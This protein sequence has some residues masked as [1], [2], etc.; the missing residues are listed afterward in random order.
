MNQLIKTLLVFTSVSSTMALVSACAETE[1]EEGSIGTNSS[2]IAAAPRI[3][4]FNRECGTSESGACPAQPDCPNLPN[5]TACTTTGSRCLT[6]PNPSGRRKVFACVPGNVNGWAFNGN[7]EGTCT[8][9]A[10]PDIPTGVAG[11][12]CTTPL[13]RCSS[14]NRVFACIPPG[15]VYIFNGYCGKNGGPACASFADNCPSLASGVAGTA[16]TAGSTCKS[17][18]TD[19]LSGKVFKCVSR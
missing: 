11:A 1:S 18:G 5:G 6:G 16:C 9:P 15:D 10:C 12:P 7:C 13:A 17:I 14:A 2:E 8:Q 4:Q 3:W 19:G